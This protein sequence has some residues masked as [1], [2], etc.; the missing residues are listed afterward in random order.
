MCVSRL[1]MRCN[2]S[3]HKFPWQR[4]FQLKYASEKQTNQQQNT[5][6]YLPF[7]LYLLLKISFHTTLFLW[8][9]LNKSSLVT[10]S[11]PFSKA[12]LSCSYSR[13]KFFSLQ[14]KVKYLFR[15]LNRQNFYK[16]KHKQEY[17][18][19]NAEHTRPPQALIVAYIW[20]DLDGVPRKHCYMLVLLIQ[21][22][23]QASVQ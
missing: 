8:G 10:L 21:G 17:S 1:W 3:A 4:A 5:T 9:S 15:F 16:Q 13:M 2:G 7:I 14:K 23:I 20:I 6:K 18:F 19:A 11:A 12:F 22:L